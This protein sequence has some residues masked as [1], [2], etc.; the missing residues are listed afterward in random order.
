MDL[1]DKFARRVDERAVAEI[2]LWIATAPH[3][4]DKPIVGDVQGAFDFWFDGGAGRIQT[5]YVEYEFTNGARAT[6][7]NPVPALTVRI[8]LAN[9][10][11]VVVQQ[12]SWGEG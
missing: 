11:R 2:L 1:R 9:G 4:R 10:C 12:E 6:V 5:G 3:R 8:D 7:G